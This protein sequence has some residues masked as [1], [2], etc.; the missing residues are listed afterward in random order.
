ML[1]KRLNVA[2][3]EGNH[4]KFLCVF[5]STLVFILIY[6]Q[7][8]T[9]N[10]LKVSTNSIQLPFKSHLTPTNIYIYMYIYI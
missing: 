6:L 2:L 3:G 1:L 9:Q 7:F 10:D 8:S 4:Y 5:F